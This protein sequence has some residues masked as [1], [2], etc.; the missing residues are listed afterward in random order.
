[1]GVITDNWVEVSL[2]EEEVKYLITY[3]K[4]V[5]R[6]IKENDEQVQKMLADKILV[7]DYKKHYEKDWW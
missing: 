2:C 1:M 7:D 6:Q 3:L 5:T 4:L